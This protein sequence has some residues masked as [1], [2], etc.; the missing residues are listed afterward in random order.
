MN[1]IPVYFLSAKKK[2]NIIS[3]KARLTRCQNTSDKPKILKANKG[4]NTIWASRVS[5]KHHLINVEY[6]SLWGSG[7]FLFF[8]NWGLEK[9]PPIFVAFEANPVNFHVTQNFFK[10]NQTWRYF[11]NCRTSN[12]PF[13]QIRRGVIIAT[14]VK[15]RSTCISVVRHQKL[16][17]FI[18]CNGE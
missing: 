13:R 16:I 4:R 1:S 14:R 2:Y 18:Y 3:P 17:F 12:K 10:G 15:K 6:P 9:Q 7:H 5:F 11:I 8:I